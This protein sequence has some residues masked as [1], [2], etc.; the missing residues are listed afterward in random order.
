L[1]LTV[2]KSPKEVLY[3]VSEEENSTFLSSHS[4]N[5]LYTK[6]SIFDPS[7]S[8]LKTKSLLVYSEDS[9]LKIIL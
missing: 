6:E 5:C 4:S 1:V 2:D 7:T 9:I 3:F 8:G